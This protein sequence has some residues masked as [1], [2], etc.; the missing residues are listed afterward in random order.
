M[1]MRKF[2]LIRGVIFSVLLIGG[3]SGIFV[4]ARNGALEKR[5]IS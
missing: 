5:N 1:A 3:G 4:L 2:F